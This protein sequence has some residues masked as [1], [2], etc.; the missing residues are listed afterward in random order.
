[1]NEG[2]RVV[3]GFRLIAC[4]LLKGQTLFEG[5]KLFVS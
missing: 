3:A 5:R 2:R 1:M 4:E